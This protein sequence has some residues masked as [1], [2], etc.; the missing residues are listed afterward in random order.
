[1]AL[2]ID[3]TVSNAPIYR[4]TNEFVSWLRQNET[5]PRP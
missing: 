5:P 1:M 3:V 4:M 2:V